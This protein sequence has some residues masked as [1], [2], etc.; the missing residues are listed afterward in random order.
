MKNRAL[1]LKQVGERL[2]IGQTSLRKL[3]VELKAYKA[4]GQWRIDESDLEAYVAAQ[5]AK[6]Q[7]RITEAEAVE[8]A[9]D[10]DA[11]LPD[12]PEEARL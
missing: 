6:R 5:K 8:K 10:P 1:S 3:F 2:G 7:P 11:L 9:F 12:V 4:G